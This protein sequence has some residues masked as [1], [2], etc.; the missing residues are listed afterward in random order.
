MKGYTL[1]SCIGTGI[2]NK[3]SGY[4]KTVYQFPDNGKKYETSLFLKAIIDTEY[5][6]IKKVVLVGTFTSGWDMLIPNPDSEE[7]IHLWGKILDECENKEKGISKESI[8]ELESRLSGWYNNIPFKIATHTDELK[9]ENVENVFST[10]MKI[11]D[12]LEPNTDILFDISHGFRSMPILVF[13]SLQLNASKIFGRKVEVIYGEYIKKEQISHVRDLS[14]YWDFYEI[15]SAIK[16]FEE[17]FDGKL[18]A[19]KIKPYWESG[20]K[21]LSRFTEIVECNFSLQIYEA[22]N[23][24]KNSLSNY[25]E[26]GK[27]QWVTDVKNSLYE[28]YKK[29]SQNADEKYPI[30]KTVWE[31]S[32]LLREKKLITQA[33]IA[34]QVAVETAITEKIDPSKIGDYDWFRTAYAISYGLKEN[35]YQKLKKIHQNNSKLKNLERLRNHIAHGGSKN[36]GD[37]PHLSNI[38]SVPSVLKSIDNAMHELFLILDEE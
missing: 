2:Y 37:Y 6:L 31:Y 34:L 3:N 1:I 16:L 33:V 14:K 30:A 26:K 27:P 15:S 35:A 8:I 25:N 13:Q 29:L 7:N 32:K 18:L 21:F 12:L 23:Q 38:P 17:K 28:I 9:Y 4:R 20:A 19:E 36:K 10:Y 24:F 5:R 22:L 11:P